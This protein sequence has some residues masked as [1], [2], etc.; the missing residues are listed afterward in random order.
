MVM[1]S[2]RNLTAAAA[3]CAA[4]LVTGAPP[5]GAA[6]A[7][8]DRGFVASTARCAAPDSA[9]AFGCTDS[10]RV[11]ICVDPDGRPVNAATTP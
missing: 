6:P 8:D 7:T 11:A 4:L 1:R 10:S 5:A 2:S 9:V 3:A